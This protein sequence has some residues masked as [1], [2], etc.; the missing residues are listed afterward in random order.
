MIQMYYA[1]F[2]PGRELNRNTVVEVFQEAGIKE[3]DL[4]RIWIKLKPPAAVHTEGQKGWVKFTENGH[5]TQDKG[6]TRT[7]VTSAKFE[8]YI[9]K[10]QVPSI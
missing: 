10:A 6:N 1:W 5:D 8:C 4:S 3:S 2:Y 7:E 9:L